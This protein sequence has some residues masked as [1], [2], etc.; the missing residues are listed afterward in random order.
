MIRGLFKGKW[1][2]DKRHIGMVVREAVVVVVRRPFQDEARSEFLRLRTT[3][4]EP[5]SPFRGQT[6]T[7]GTYVLQLPD[8]FTPRRLQTR[9]YASTKCRPWM[10]N[11]PPVPVVDQS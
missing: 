3:V 4:I 7:L 8:R 1:S 11:F 10:D 9:P 2:P 5:S 6:A